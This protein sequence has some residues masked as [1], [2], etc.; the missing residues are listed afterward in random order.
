MVNEELM[1]EIRKDPV[2]T[3][4]TIKKILGCKDS[5]A[6]VVL[7]RLKD[8]RIL[9]KIM[10]GK[11]TTHDNI[12]SIATNIW[13]PSYLTLWT[14]SSWK[15]YTEQV[16]NQ[17]QVATTKYKNSIKFE[18]YEIKPIKFS[19]ELFFGF[20][21]IKS[22]GSDIFVVEDEKHL[23]DSLSFRDK[24]GNPSEILKIFEN[25]DVEKDKIINHLKRIDN[26]SLIKRCGFLLEK[27]KGMDISDV[28]KL[29]DRNY[30]G[31]F[32]EGGENTDSKWRLKYDIKI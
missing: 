19:K 16:I 11:Y 24:M 4:A 27:V 22:G 26:K 31:L 32:G 20:K 2:I 7:N 13:T 8:R 5:Y 10:K 17:I 23:I 18:N 15:G 28:F 6:Y 3:K 29:E 30:P 14:A 25:C 1:E 21:K 12:Y 9:K